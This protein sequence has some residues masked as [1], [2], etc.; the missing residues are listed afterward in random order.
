MSL[1][2]LF[3]FQHI[4][5]T[6]GGFFVFHTPVSSACDWSLGVDS[7]SIAMFICWLIISNSLVYTILTLLHHLLSQ[8][9]PFHTL[10]SIPSIPDTKCHSQ[11]YTLVS[12]WVANTKFTQLDFK[13]SMFHSKAVLW[14][15]GDCAAILCGGI[16]SQIAQ[17]FLSLD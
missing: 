5:Q 8:H 7:A 10:L 13:S 4:T 14:T 12:F 1:S 16:L 9:I 3:D 6:P 2:M 11:D 17:E 15:A